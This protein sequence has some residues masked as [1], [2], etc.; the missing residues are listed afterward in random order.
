[1]ENQTLVLLNFYDKIPLK[2]N[3]KNKNNRVVP[4]AVVV[5]LLF[6]LVLFNAAL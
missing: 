4:H 2:D 1:M 5:D 6:L 3:Y